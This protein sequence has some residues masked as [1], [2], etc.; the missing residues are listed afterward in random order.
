MKKKY[1]ILEIETVE[2]EIPNGYNVTTRTEYFGVTEGYPCLY[3]TL[4]DAENILMNKEG[5]IFEKFT[6]LP[7]YCNRD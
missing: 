7:I 6:I 1:L 5:N 3:D 2:K 4:E